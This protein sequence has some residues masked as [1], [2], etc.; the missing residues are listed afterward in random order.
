MRQILLPAL[1]TLAL[2][3]ALV[4]ASPNPIS[5][6]TAASEPAQDKAE[7]PTAAKASL[8]EEFSPPPGYRAKKRGKKTVYCKK[9]P[10]SGT[11]F[12]S[13]ICYD[14][15]QLREMERSREIGNASFDQARKVCSGLE[16]CTGG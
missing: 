6:E 12:A 14:E 11:R 8:Q 7:S 1:V 3:P 9:S 15:E 16:P 5:N 2:V 4:S 13:E 10:E